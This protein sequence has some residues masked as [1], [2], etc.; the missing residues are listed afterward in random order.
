MH[1][2]PNTGYTH[3][4]SGSDS[5]L[6]R[7]GSRGSHRDVDV[8]DSGDSTLSDLDESESG[9][10]SGVDVDPNLPYP[11]IAPVALRYL[12]QTTRPRSWCLALISNPYPL[13]D[14]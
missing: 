3:C 14:T 12:S 5:G 9:S 11:G 4:R 13:F 8:F 10:G 2:Y 7:R 1:Y 6:H